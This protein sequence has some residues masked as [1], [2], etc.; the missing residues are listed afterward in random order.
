MLLVTGGYSSHS[1]SD[2]PVYQDVQ[3]SAAEGVL[4]VWHTLR[5][6]TRTDERRTLALSPA[7]MLE[8]HSF[9]TAA[10]RGRE[11]CRQG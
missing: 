11:L 1:N 9:P 2:E 3:E 4:N 10:I 8:K 7:N 6:L 5:L